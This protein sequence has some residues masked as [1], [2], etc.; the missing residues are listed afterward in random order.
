MAH[1]WLY[2]LLSFSICKSRTGRSSRRHGGRLVFE[3]RACMVGRYGEER[4]GVKQQKAS[5]EGRYGGTKGRCNGRRA[6]GLLESE[7]E[8][9]DSSD[10]GYDSDNGHQHAIHPDPFSFPLIL[11]GLASPCGQPVLRNHK[12]SLAQ[13]E[14]C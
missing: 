6:G 10:N 7:V 8:E 2:G 13:H 14:A 5:T 4:A 3:P 1:G 9:Y 11:V 12:H